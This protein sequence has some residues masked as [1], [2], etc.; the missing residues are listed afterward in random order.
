MAQ[1]EKYQASSLHGTIW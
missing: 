1:K